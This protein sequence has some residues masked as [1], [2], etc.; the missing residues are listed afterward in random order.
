MS[1]RRRR[2]RAVGV[3]IGFGRMFRAPRQEKVRSIQ[4]AP[5]LMVSFR[6][7]LS[8]NTLR[9]FSGPGECPLTCDGRSAIAALQSFQLFLRFARLFFPLLAGS[10]DSLSGEARTG[11]ADSPAHDIRLAR[12]IGGGLIRRRW[13]PS[14]R[15]LLRLSR[16]GRSSQLG[17]I[18]RFRGGATDANE[19]C[20]RRNQE[21]SRFTLPD[22][23]GFRN[24]RISAPPQQRFPPLRREPVVPR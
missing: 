2:L 22:R 14:G 18:S 7:V 13:L 5:H 6:R 19:R 17:Q 11:G 9:R 1:E 3:Y 23:Y 20:S 24:F 16:F 21:R 15:L 8:R 4:I 10:A 12:F